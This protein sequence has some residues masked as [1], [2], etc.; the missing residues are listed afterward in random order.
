[1]YYAPL[2]AIYT[3][4]TW[5]EI[6]K[7]SANKL[8]CRSIRS[9]AGYSVAD[10]LCTIHLTVPNTHVRGR[11]VISLIT[12]AVKLC[13]PWLWSMIMIHDCDSWLWFIHDCD[14]WLWFMIMIHDCD[15]WLYDCDSFVIVIHDCDSWLWFIQL[16]WLG[17]IHDFDSWLWFMIVIHDCDSWFN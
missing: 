12:P 10:L 13:D 8:S 17:F 5:S 15:S 7:S 9:V 3:T 4:Q 11:S 1:M 14:S 2:Y 6:A 16:A